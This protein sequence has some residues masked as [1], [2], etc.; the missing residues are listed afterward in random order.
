MNRPGYRNFIA[1]IA[2]NDSAADPGNDDP[3]TVGEL[4]TSCM[5]ADMYM[6]DP[7]RV[8]NDV[9]K[10]RNKHRISKE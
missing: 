1:W 5:V 2:E 4:V 9:V 8:G 6:V 10:Y 7:L 3:E